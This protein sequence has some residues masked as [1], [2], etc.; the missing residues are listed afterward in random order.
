MPTET[1]LEQLAAQ[2][3]DLCT[4]DEDDGY[5]RVRCSQC[6]ALCINGVACHETGCVNT[7][8]ADA[9]EDDFAFDD[10]LCT[11]DGPDNTMQDCPYHG[12]NDD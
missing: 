3:F 10:I 5:I 2:G 1:K 12:W 6:E 11:C 7:V 8:R 9:D 4:V